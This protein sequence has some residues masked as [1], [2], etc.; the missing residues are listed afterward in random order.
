M[1]VSGKKSECDEFFR[2]ARERYRILLR[3]RQGEPRPWTEDPIFRSFRFCNVHRED[4][5]T[6]EWFN[7]HVRHVVATDP[8]CSLHA[9]MLFRW[10][11][12]IETGK[13]IWDQL[14]RREWRPDIVRAKLTGVS[15][16]VTGAYVIK[17]PAGMS[18]LEGIIWCMD[19]AVPHFEEIIGRRRNF[20]SL[21]Y[22]WERL[23]ELPYL[24]PFMAYEVV[25]DLRHTVLLNHAI[26][27]NTW[28]N[29]GPGA[30]RGLGLIWG[31]PDRYRY[32][33]RV[34]QELMNTDMCDLLAL[35]RREENW[36]KH[37]PSWEMREVEH[38]LCEFAKYKKAEAGGRLKNRYDGG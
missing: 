13:R 31:E 37:W 34:H 10:F 8:W 14:L 4:D 30:A 28:A 27:I 19:R 35:S 16:L 23:V 5:R 15:P 9:C 2:T 12:R 11:N 22:M 17:T 18:K 26:D 21:R 7:H 6:T 32:T 25:T 29:A 1:R 33:S 3:R 38:W 20:S 24:G 36:P